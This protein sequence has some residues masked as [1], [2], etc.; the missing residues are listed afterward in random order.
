MSLFI[1]TDYDKSDTIEIDRFVSNNSG[2]TRQNI[3][4]IHN[5][6]VCTA[7]INRSESLQI[8]QHLIREFGFSEEEVNG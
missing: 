1:E 6:S 5:S 2:I 7:T 8:V 3:E 4:I